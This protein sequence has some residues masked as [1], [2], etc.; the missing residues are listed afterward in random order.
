MPE[1]VEK[2]C[3]FVIPFL[4]TETF[5]ERILELYENPHLTKKLGENAA[6]KVR[7]NH[8]IEISAPKVLE[9]IERFWN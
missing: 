5:A 2:D 3:G 4:D 7:E 1:F 6:K 9:I 8:D